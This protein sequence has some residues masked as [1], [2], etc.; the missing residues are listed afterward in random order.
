MLER[1]GLLQRPCRHP[2]PGALPPKYQFVD[3]YAPVNP[4]ERKAHFSALSLDREPET[5]VRIIAGDL[6]DCPNVMLPFAVIDTIRYLH[7][8][9]NHFSRPHKQAGKIK[10]WSRIDYILLSEQHAHLLVSGTTYLDALLSDHRPVC[11]G[12][13]C[14]TAES[15][16]ALP[17]LP[18]TSSQLLRVNTRV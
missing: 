17:S 9:S 10:S 12:I 5:T 3:Y 1:A 8:H 11:V 14:P 6:N 7:S 18:E 2:H 4:K 13:A 15:T 16:S